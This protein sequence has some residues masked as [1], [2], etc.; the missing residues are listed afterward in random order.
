MKIN[1]QGRSVAI[2][3]FLSCSFTPIICNFPFNVNGGLC[4]G[5]SCATRRRRMWRTSETAVRVV[6]HNI[7]YDRLNDD[8]DFLSLLSG[9]CV[10]VW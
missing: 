4:F 5:I 8:I 7:N 6:L 9:E 2:Q 3:P 1:G 10:K